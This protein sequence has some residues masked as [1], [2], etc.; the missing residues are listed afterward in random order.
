M[1]LE[2]LLAPDEALLLEALLEGELLDEEPLDEEPLDE[3]PLDEAA[4][5]APAAPPWLEAF[6]WP[7]SI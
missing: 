6:F 1:L 2:A 3:A 4:D 5:E 7:A